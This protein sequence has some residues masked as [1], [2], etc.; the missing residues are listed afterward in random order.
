MAKI[1]SFFVTPFVSTL[2]L[3]IYCSCRHKWA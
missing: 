2:F 1:L 3:E